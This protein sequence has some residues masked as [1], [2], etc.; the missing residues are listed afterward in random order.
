MRN[1]CEFFPLPF[2]V[3]LISTLESVTWAKN[4]LHSNPTN[5]VFDAKCLICSLSGFFFFPSTCFLPPTHN[6]SRC[7]SKCEAFRVWTRQHKSVAQCQLSK[8]VIHPLGL[9]VAQTTD[10]V[11]NDANLLVCVCVDKK[12]RWF[13]WFHNTPDSS[14]TCGQ[15]TYFFSFSFLV[16]ANLAR[17]LR[18]QLSEFHTSPGRPQSPQ[19]VRHTA[20]QYCEY[21]GCLCVH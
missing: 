7:R 17:A 13:H 11:A 12:E 18:A 1:D 4:V 9:Q 20:L 5:A 15:F 19:P 2:T 14:A 16:V 8:P 10:V 3:T 6:L 21:A